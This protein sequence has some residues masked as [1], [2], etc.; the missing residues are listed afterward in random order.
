M[1]IPLS[2]TFRWVAGIYFGTGH[3]SRH[4]K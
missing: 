4:N 3:H 1:E 2:I